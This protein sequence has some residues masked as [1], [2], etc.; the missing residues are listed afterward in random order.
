[1]RGIILSVSILSVLC[2]H[3]ALAEPWTNDEIRLLAYNIY[4]GGQATPVVPDRGHEWL[5]VIRSRNP[6]VILLQEANGWLPSDSN[7]VAA[8][9]ESLNVSF[10]GELPYSGWVGDANS[11]Y[12]LAILSRLTVLSVEIVTEAVLDSALFTLSKGLFHAVLEDSGGPVHVIDVHLASGE[13]R[14]DREMEARVLLEVLDGIP[15]GEPVWIGGDFNS[16]SPVD[17]AT[18]S[19][20]A[21]ACDLGA[22]PVEAIGWEPV[23]YLLERG[24]NDAFRYRYPLDSGYTKHARSFYETPQNPCM[25]VD[26]L[27]R[28]PDAPWWVQSAEVVTDG[29]ADVAS[30]HYA[31]FAVYRRPTLTEAAEPEITAGDTGLRCR[32]NP[33]TSVTTIEFETAHVAPVRVG[34]Y[35]VLGRHVRSLVSGAAPAGAAHLTWDGSDDSGMDLPG[36]W[37]FVRVESEQRVE[38][39]RV[40]L[41]R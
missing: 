8:Y 26:F 19:P 1:M 2:A 23:E 34:I 33:F 28:S 15:A 29:L 5:E 13:M 24:Y 12:D 37:Y 3:G 25:R 35:S 14:L 10:P 20:T 39:T 38:T 40:L 22:D 17:A 32:P 41:V 4:Y 30:D 36:G 18:G 9:V 6:D 7:Y 31:V 11:T 27:F 16:Y 21:P